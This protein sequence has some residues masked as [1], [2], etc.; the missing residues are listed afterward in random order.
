MGFARRVDEGVGDEEG[1]CERGGVGGEVVTEEREGGG[2][3][4]EGGEG[5]I[6]GD[7]AGVERWWGEGGEVAV[8]VDL[9]LGG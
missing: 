6:W 9:D 8:D 5:G 7:E 3:G 1:G 2:P 4:E